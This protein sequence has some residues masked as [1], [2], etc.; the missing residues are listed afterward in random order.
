MSLSR[1]ASGIMG[2]ADSTLDMRE[3]PE[4]GDLAWLAAYLQRQE[5]AEAADGS[6]TTT[7]DPPDVPSGGPF[8]RIIDSANSGTSEPSPLAS[9]VSEV[10][11]LSH[12]SET[13]DRTSWVTSVRN[14]SRTRELAH[15]DKHVVW[16]HEQ[17]NFRIAKLKRSNHSPRL[18]GRR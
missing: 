3:R 12:A 7:S 9:P 2:Q 8:L 15:V 1:F 18:A 4:G 13:G 5:A 6:E 11:R 10:E 14:A 17:P 16:A